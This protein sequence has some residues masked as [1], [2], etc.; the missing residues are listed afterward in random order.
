[1]HIVLA[2]RINYSFC[3]DSIFFSAI[4]ALILF[5]VVHIDQ[6]FVFVVHEPYCPIRPYTS[7]SALIFSCISLL[8]LF[9]V[10][11]GIIATNNCQHTTFPMMPPKSIASNIN[12]SSS[13]TSYSKSFSTPQFLHHHIP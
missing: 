2:V 10:L 9:K 4:V 5:P 12:T 11:H 1:M 8:E 7:I 13:A 6:Q 3:D